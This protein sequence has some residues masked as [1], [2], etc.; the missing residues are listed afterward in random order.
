[1]TLRI[2]YLLL[3]GVVSLNENM[4]QSHLIGQRLGNLGDEVNERFEEQRTLWW[5]YQQFLL[6]VRWLF[7]M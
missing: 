6:F 1:M 4:E 2:V 7:T 5:W 3:P